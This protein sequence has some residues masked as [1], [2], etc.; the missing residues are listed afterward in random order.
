MLQEYTEYEIREMKERYFKIKIRINSYNK[1][2]YNNNN[3][4]NKLYKRIKEL[5]SIRSNLIRT[6]SKFYEY[7]NLK[8]NK[9][10]VLRENYYNTKFARDYSEEMLDFINGRE[11]LKVT[12]CIDNAVDRVMRKINEV[13]YIIGELKDN[14]NILRNRISDLEYEKRLI[15]QKGVI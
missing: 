2:I 8:K 9:F 15:L 4:I 13:Y 3:E 7:I 10:Q 14:N 1:E 11:S 12:E 6:N 5:E